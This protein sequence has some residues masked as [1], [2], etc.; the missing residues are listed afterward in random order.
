MPE[1]EELRA[2]AHRH[3][4]DDPAEAARFRRLVL[5]TLGDDAEAFGSEIGQLD[6]LFHAL[7]I[8]HQSGSE[9]TVWAARELLVSE[10]DA[11]AV[12]AGRNAERNKGSQGC[13]F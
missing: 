9:D 8:A 2:Y 3:S 10:I 7:H 5:D 11:I 6:D 12:K 1:F 13:D 4:L